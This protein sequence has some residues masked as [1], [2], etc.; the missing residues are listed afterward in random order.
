MR[1][2]FCYLLWLGLLWGHTI[3]GDRTNMMDVAWGLYAQSASA[4]ASSTHQPQG[5]GWEEGKES[6]DTNQTS[7]FPRSAHKYLCGWFI[8]SGAREEIKVNCN[9]YIKLGLFHDTALHTMLV[10]IKDKAIYHKAYWQEYWMATHT[11]GLSL[12]PV[13]SAVLIAPPS[14]VLKH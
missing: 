5:G 11:L 7:H 8:N 1:R 4:V 10:P 2:L 14:R 9:V 13:V 12:A 3:A 6:R